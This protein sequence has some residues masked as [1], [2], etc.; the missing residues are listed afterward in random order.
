M[1]LQT[2]PAHRLFSE[3]YIPHSGDDAFAGL[4]QRS[5]VAGHLVAVAV[6][7]HRPWY[8][9]K[10]KRAERH[11]AVIDRCVECTRPIGTWGCWYSDGAGELVPYCAD[12]AEREF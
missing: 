11:E 1:C 6:A 8:T 3:N 10:R 7:G 5:R 12:C 2:E 9:T 4:A